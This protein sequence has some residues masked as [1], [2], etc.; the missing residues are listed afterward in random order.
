[1]NYIV[2]KIKTNS[3]KIFEIKEFL[4]REECTKLIQLVEKE[5][6]Y[7]NSLENGKETIYLYK[8]SDDFYKELNIRIHSVLDIPLEY[9][10]V[11]QVQ[12]YNINNSIDEH[13]DFFNDSIEFEKKQL[14]KSGQRTWTFIIYLNDDFEGGET[15]FPIE[16]LKIT[17]EIGKAILWKNLEDGYPNYNTKHTGLPVKS[18]Y[19][20]ILTKWFREKLI[21]Y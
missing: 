19:K 10:E 16:N 5:K 13:Y 12:K 8:L 9:G 2:N 6:I 11:I 17:P 18:N 14:D 15:Y 21:K 20:Y 1:M 3:I 7:R 4:K